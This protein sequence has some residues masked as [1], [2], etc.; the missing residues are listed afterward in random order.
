MTRFGPRNDRGVDAIPYEMC[1]AKTCA[2]GDPGMPVV[3]HCRIV[4]FVARDL[5]S[6]LPESVAALLPR[7]A[8]TV[9]ALHDVGKVSPGFQKKYF[10]DH[11]KVIVPNLAA[12]PLA[13]NFCTD[14]AAISGA[15]VNRFLGREFELC[16][17]AWVVAVHHGAIRQAELADDIG[18]IFGGADWAD[19]RKKLIGVLVD[20]FGEVSI[21]LD[22]AGQTLLA[23]LVSVADWIGSDETWFPPEGLPDTCDPAAKAQEAVSACGFGFPDLTPDLSFRDIFG[24][25]PYAMQVEF[26]AQVDKRGLYILEAPMGMGK[27]EAALFAAYKLMQSGKNSG[28]YFG[29]PTRLTSDKIHERVDP[30]LEKICP[31]GA[32]AKLA[33]GTAWLRAFGHGAVNRD[34]ESGA[35]W[36]NPHKRKLLYPFAVGTIDQAL[37]SVLRVKHFFVRACGLAGKVVILDEVHSYD[38]YTGTLL[39][40]LVRR[41]L[42]LN[43]TVIVLSATLS[44]SRRAR[45][46]SGQSALSGTEPY[47]LIT[48][49][50]QGRV[51]ATAA[52]P[53]PP[54][55]YRVSLA[56]WDTSSVATAAVE[57]AQAGHCV[58]CI[59][60]TVAKAQEWF[61][62]VSCT[63]IEE[64][65][66]LGLLHSKFPGFLREE[67]ESHWLN[68]LGP[69]GTRPKGCV[70][71]ATQVVEQSVDID[72]D[73]LIT[74]LAPTD[75]LLQRMGRQWRHPD[76]PRPSELPETVIVTRDPSEAA[77][78]EEIV[79]ALGRS[80]CKVYSPY[81]LWRSL[82]VWKA[83][84]GVTLPDEIRSLIEATYADNRANEPEA[85]LRLRADSEVRIETLRSHALAARAEVIAM[86]TGDDREGAATRYSDLPTTQALIVQSVET[87]GRRTRLRLLEADVAVEVDADRVDYP[88]TAKLHRN[89]IPI[90]THLLRPLGKPRTPDYLRKHFYEP[91]PVLTWKEETGEVLWNGHSTGLSYTD[92]RGL[93]RRPGETATR[94]REQDLYSE[95]EDVDLLDKNGSDW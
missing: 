15:A 94:I 11:S 34:E 66:E 14:H 39:D 30:F 26:A 41:L 53:P 91:T 76:R 75:M 12:M 32:S 60:N 86:P 19:E 7:S 59:S 62:A 4:A 21:D 18:G 74:E 48:R 64:R 89:L 29:L 78:I 77:D 70:L 35:A 5:I 13:G 95:Y 80:N 56:D 52:L 22:S 23:G 16:P 63:M 83:R 71:V 49:E 9:A 67:K 55:T 3:E 31:A 81:I 54:K 6:R 92:R 2:N 68:S 36:F 33:H 85:V 37:L 50:V 51:S 27:T 72:A 46:T 28:L 1:R 20:E 84:A 79:E 57:K 40:L 88:V 90:A 73:F 43:C 8:A 87:T 65:F 45:L 17:P 25:E 47:P 58:L 10:N 61:D 93:G 82:Q 69:T 38:M 24:A 44:G 42:E